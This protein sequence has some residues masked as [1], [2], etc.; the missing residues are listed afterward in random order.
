[1]SAASH[2][3]RYAAPSSASEMAWRFALSGRG[4]IASPF[5]RARLTEPRPTADWL[6]TV[7]AVVRA[8]FH[9]PPTMLA[10]LL[11]P[12]V[13]CSR[14]RLRFEG[15]SSCCSVYARLDLDDDVLDPSE[16][17]TGTTNVDF[18]ANMRAALTAVRAEERVDLAL[19]LE[20]LALERASE[21][22]LERRVE[23]PNR[24]LRGFAEVQAT[25]ARMTRVSELSCGAALQLLRGLPRERADGFLVLQGGH[26]RL[27]QTRS[28]GALRVGAVERLRLLEPIVRHAERVVIF[29]VN[30]LDE[31]PLAFVLERRGM[32]LSCVMSADRWRG[33]SGEGGLLR[34]LAAPVDEGD[35]AALRGRLA[36][37]DDVSKE[38]T[39]ASPVALTHLA[40]EGS[41][42]FDL[43][44]TRYFHRELPFDRTSLM[45]LQ[46]RLAEARRLLE[47]GAAREMA[48]FVEV[49]GAHGRY[50]L[51]RDAGS[52][53]WSCTCPWFAKHRGERGPCKHALAAELLTAS[54]QR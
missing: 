33:F 52:G 53:E 10:P 30:D 27:S 21:T 19:G 23:L 35:L 7:A 8:R 20:G 12:V 24:W 45:G 16:R 50:R 34:E 1:M 6:L 42:G 40:V 5:L 4:G 29:G 26:P 44:A 43:A 2:L 25:Q 37:Q 49:D 3:Y 32:R 48:G 15:F 54:S 36:W 38:F 28:K 39:Q 17:S 14:S 11:D 46:P 18:G 31:S 9:L 22:T 13:T 47:C 41:V 51:S